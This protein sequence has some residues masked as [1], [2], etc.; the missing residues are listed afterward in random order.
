MRARLPLRGLP[1]LGEVAPYYF[2]WMSH[3]S[4]DPWWDW[5]EVRG[6]Y[7]R[8][9]AAVLNLS[10]WYDEAYGPEGALTNFLGLVASRQGKDPRAELVI[11]PWVHGIATIGRT[12]AGEREFSEAAALDYDALVLDFMD[13]HLKRSAVPPPP[14]V[15]VFVMGENAGRSADGWPLAG[16]TEQVL[17]LSAGAGSGSGG[18]LPAGRELRP[19]T[20]YL[21]SD[22]LKPVLDN[23]AAAPGAHDYRAL[24]LRPDVAGFETEPLSDPLVVVGRV[25]AEI[26]VS[27]D[28]PDA[29]LW[30]KLH[31]V[32][33][34]GTAFNLMSPGLDLMRASYRDGGPERKLLT[35]GEP[36]LLRF[37][38]LMTGNRFDRG[39]RLRM[40]LTSSFLPHFSRNL[41]TGEDEAVSARSRAARITIHFDAQRPSRIVL[42]V[43]P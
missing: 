37:E 21:L 28:A 30:V 5:A 29:D 15:R 39:H 35:P 22:P 19:G 24:A 11:G 34:D 31:D 25:R 9:S 26:F 14:R 41:N 8:T 1:E 12:R 33:P 36:V 20:S 43:M 40:V 3:P 2:E 42:P 10:G 27:V 32:A 17:Q 4:G 18:L 13:R 38:D 23:Y 16:T 7:E 6:H